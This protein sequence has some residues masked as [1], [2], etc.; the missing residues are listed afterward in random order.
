[1]RFAPAPLE[2]AAL[3]LFAAS[4]AEAQLLHGRVLDRASGDPV[5]SAAVLVVNPDESIRSGAITDRDGMFYLR[6]APGTFLL[7]VQRVGYATTGSV[8]L[9]L[10]R[11]DTLN[12][13]V[14][15]SVLAVS[16]DSLTVTGV[17]G[18]PRDPSGFFKRQAEVG[19]R[20]LGPYE[21]ERRRPVSPADL[22]HDIPGF[23]VIPRTGGYRVL[24]TGRNRRCIPTVYVDGLLAHRGTQTNR[25]VQASDEDGVLLES[26][27]NA[28]AIRAM[29]AYQS[30]ATAPVRFRPVGPIGGGDCGVLVFWTRIGFGR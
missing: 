28:N 18:A 2:T 17:P 1:M 27:V 6:T 26:L 4:S 23:Q 12:F 7:R 11:T 15:L 14:K 9:E 13:E 30:G 8:P 3:L 5:A 21:V 22:L 29:E 24:M 16:V 20:F 19:G 25:L 10:S